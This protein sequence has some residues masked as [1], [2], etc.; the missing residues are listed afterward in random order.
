VSSSLPHETEAVWELAE[1][2]SVF[3]HEGAAP[4]GAEQTI[5][6]D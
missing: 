2:R 1:N 5:V 4:G 3:I 6:V